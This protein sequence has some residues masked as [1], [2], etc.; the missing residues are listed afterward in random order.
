M[1]GFK[2]FLIMASISMLIACS[3][4][5][6]DTSSSTENSTF[7]LGE[8]RLVS[9]NTY[10]TNDMWPELKNSAIVDLMVCVKDRVFLQDIVGED[11]SIESD[12]NTQSS[13]SNID[14]CIKWQERFEFDYIA[15]EV[16][17]KLNGSVKGKTIHKGRK[18]FKLA[19][20]P[21]TKELVDLDYGSALKTQSIGTDVKINSL[22]NNLELGNHDITVTEVEFEKDKTRLSL[23]V[24]TN[25]GVTHRK[26]DGKK[27]PTILT[28]GLFS[29]DFVLF[30]RE[31]GSNRRIEL[32]SATSEERLDSEGRLVSFLNFDIH[33]LI[34]S[35]A[36]IEL[37]IS[38][39]AVDAP[40]E[41]GS[42]EGF[43]SIES[44][45]KGTS[46][47]LNSMSTSLSKMRI[48][49]N[50]FKRRK[51]GVV[52]THGFLIEKIEVNSSLEVP[53]EVSGNFVRDESDRFV[54]AEIEI[55]LVDTLVYDGIN[56]QFEIEL[57]DLKTG[58]V[59]YSKVRDTSNKNGSGELIIEVTIEYGEN[60]EYDYREYQLNMKGTKKPFLGLKQQ[61]IVYINPRLGS[62]QF[63]LDSKDRTKPKLPKENQPEIYIDK[64]NFK[65]QG[66]NENTLY[67][68]NKRLELLGN[69][70]VRLSLSPKVLVNHQYQGGQVAPDK[71][72]TGKYE[73][74]FLILTPLRP[75]T[76]SLTGPI[77]LEDFE[78]IT[79]VHRKNISS[80]VGEMFVDVDLPHL[81][82][83]RLALS[84]KN[85]AVLQLRSMKEGSMLKPAQFIG[86]IEIFRGQ[87]EV[88]SIYDTSIKSDKNE[89]LLAKNNDIIAKVVK[90]IDKI[91][92]KLQP[93]S[94]IENPFIQF[95]TDL[96]SNN[97]REKVP[98]FNHK[99]IRLENKQVDF[100]FHRSER[101]FIDKFKLKVSERDLEKF[102]VNVDS[103]TEF[104]RE[105]C[106]SFYSPR[107]RTNILS[108]RIKGLSKD[109]IGVDYKR[110][111]KDPK[112]HIAVNE[113][114]F[115]EKIL[116]QPAKLRDE[117]G[118]Q[119]VIEHSNKLDRSEAYFKSK[120]VMHSEINGIRETNFWGWS[121][122]GGLEFGFQLPTVKTPKAIAM[123]SLDAGQR[124]DVYGMKQNAEIASNQKRIINQD[125][126]S[127][128]A[129]SV[130]A[131]FEARI[132]KCIMISPRE[133]LAVLP[134]RG[135]ESWWSQVYNKAHKD[136]KKVL[137]TSEKRHVVCKRNS[138]DETLSESWFFI[139]LSSSST[140]DAADYGM[141]K[142]S[143]GQTLRG[144]KAYK[145]YRRIELSKDTKFVFN[146][147]SNEAVIELYKKYMG[148]KGRNVRY[149]KSLGVGYPGL[150]EGHS[151]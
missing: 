75:L 91:T 59:V 106:K 117:T 112:S 118:R 57:V 51:K 61:R 103:T 64:F 24:N 19:L 116:T 25:V 31:K 146:T 149:K 80:E 77:D 33:D 139:K 145:E 47:K 12:L 68:V 99:L 54:T 113:L 107:T 72:M 27:N 147:Q 20:N 98:V 4:D 76:Q 34:G 121:A 66:N 67:K 136:D 120:G 88:T 13:P 102:I 37:V 42:Y 110:C 70:V 9:F 8:V 105:L 62:T 41:L 26:I 35:Q 83:E 65:F 28:D 95:K 140:D 143:I 21:W 100:K 104:L 11:F 14:G 150:I 45:I 92:D 49:S 58:K 130:N 138:R 151:R 44:L 127:F 82:D 101:N 50:E 22:K 16:F 36:I 18:E 3:S 74:N 56:S 115:I 96:L 40:F 129:S 135:T 90:N 84:Y 131:Q 53:G 134:K 71:L 142:N 23:Q 141:A 29:T 126:L 48:N 144:I 79:A 81:F 73:L 148:R 109:Y 122:H 2:N 93:D 111:F 85:I 78:V 137:V 55:D 69:R 132:K 52:S 30:Q 87:Q 32:A 63:L 43:I 133:V 17:Y 38:T 39:K 1:G 123:L 5:V 94:E 86:Q 46:G 7:E 124:T 128:I 108:A 119:T 60:F 6:D 15:D 114:R 10:S 125:G 89:R 97:I